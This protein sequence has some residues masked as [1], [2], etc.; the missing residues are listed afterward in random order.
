MSSICMLHSMP[1]K[2]G[3]STVAHQMS[4]IKW[5]NNKSR[6][7]IKNIF[8][9]TLT[10]MLFH[11]SIH[12]SIH[13]FDLSTYPLIPQ[14]LH[15]SNQTIYTE[16]TTQ[17]IPFVTASSFPLPVF[18]SPLPVFSSPLPIAS[19]FLDVSFLPPLQL[20]SFFFPV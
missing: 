4:F 1:T 7:L 3:T 6:D 20:I 16:S 13:S 5:P 12:L 15:S 10:F 18:S 9:S 19:T 11:L 2:S 14:M 8:S 17:Y